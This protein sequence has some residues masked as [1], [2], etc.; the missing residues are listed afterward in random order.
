MI[1][2]ATSNPIITHMS[3]MEETLIDQNKLT[4]ETIQI[5]C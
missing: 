1:I 4:P 2:N 3:H 5:N